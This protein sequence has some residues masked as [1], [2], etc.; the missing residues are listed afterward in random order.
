MED[1]LG[2]AFMVFAPLLA[3]IITWLILGWRRKMDIAAD[4][5]LFEPGESV[6]D[7]ESCP[8]CHGTGIWIGTTCP[9]CDGNGDLL[10]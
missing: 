8:Q 3:G 4:D 10:V 1:I 2:V 5:D 9:K 6:I 7:P